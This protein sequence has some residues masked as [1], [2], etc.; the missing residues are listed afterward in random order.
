M[1]D[2]NAAISALEQQNK[3]FKEAQEQKRLLAEKIQQMNSQMLVGGKQIEDTPQFRSAL[4]EKQRIIKQ[5]YQKK[6]LEDRQ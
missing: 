2:K 5:E 3:N 4:E 1:E 6:Q